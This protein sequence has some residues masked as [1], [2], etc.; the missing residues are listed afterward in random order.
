MKK[1]WLFIISMVFVIGVLASCSNK[2]AASSAQDGK[3]EIRYGLWD[4]SQVPAIEQIIKNF[5]K[6]NPDIKVKVELTPYK[7]Y[8]QKLETAAAGDALPDV[9]WMNGPNI[10]RFVNGEVLLPLNE[11]MKDDDFNLQNYPDSV[12]DLYTIDGKTYGIPKDYDTTGLWYN[13]K[14][15]DEAGL[16]YPDE[17]WT[18]DKMKDAAK[19]L[20]NKDKGT[21]GFASVMG[22]QGGY[23]DL[24]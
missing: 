5:N 7:Q 16:S 15:F 12:N 11:Y 13:K 21:Y 23:Y 20:T 19:K 3:V 10:T 18:W 17:T 1:N 6:E 9:L 8:F 14:L 24:I 22:N 4:K 2:E